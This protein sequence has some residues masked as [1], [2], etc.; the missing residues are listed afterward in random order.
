MKWSQMKKTT[1]NIKHWKWRKWR[2]EIKISKEM[3]E[4]EARKATSTTTTTK[5]ITNYKLNDMLIPSTGSPSTSA[6]S[7]VKQAPIVRK[8]GKVLFTVSCGL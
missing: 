7:Q 8:R 4:E 3:N 6:A 1:W 2:V 5:E